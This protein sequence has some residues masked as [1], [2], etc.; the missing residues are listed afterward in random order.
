MNT[1]FNF[2]D[3]YKDF[4]VIARE[5]LPHGFNVLKVPITNTPVYF[6]D[7]IQIVSACY[8]AAL[9]KDA[10]IGLN[11]LGRLKKE[12]TIIGLGSNGSLKEKIKLNDLL[13]PS[14]ISCE[15]YGN[16]G[17]VF[18]PDYKIMKS[19][20][21]NIEN[22]NLKVKEYN[23][24]SVYAV[25][26]EHTNHKN[27]TNSLY[28]AGEVDC[29]DCSESYILAKFARENGLSF[30]ILLY[31]S[32]DPKNHIANLKK[33]EFDKRALNFDLLLNKIGYEVLNN[34]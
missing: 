15:Y 12:D 28:P 18:L 6:D 8:G 20:K 19:I 1:L 31:A 10:L 26:D 25:F 33:E 29:I 23:H 2:G 16:A 9:V 27:Y 32:D 13:V 14:Y 30:G 34:K 5:I 4:S 3:V 21:K 22:R 7:S 11:F 17:R 24:G